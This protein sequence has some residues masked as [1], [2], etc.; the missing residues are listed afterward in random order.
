VPHTERLAQLA[1]AFGANLQPGQILFIQAETGHEALARA[2]A[3][4]AYRL[5]ARFVDVSY[6]DPHVKR[7]RIQ[8]AE[9]DTLDF[10]PPWYGERML[11]LGER[12]CARVTIA[13]STEPGILD[14]LDPGRAGRD[15][16][17]RLKEVGKVVNDRT[18][19]WTIVPFP[20]RAWAAAVYPDPDGD[21]LDRLWG[22][23]AHV[24]RLDEPD[25][26]AAWE[27]RFEETGRAAAALTDRH[28]GAIH[29]EG[30]GTDLTIGLLASSGWLNAAFST[31]DG[32]DH[33]PN[34]PSEEVFTTPDPQRADGVV[35]S[36]KPLVFP[37]GA[38]VRGLRVRFE[39]GRAAEID[40][41]ENAEILRSQCAKDEGASRLGEV[42]LVDGE[43]R[44]GPLG[45]VFYDTLLDEN[46]ASHVAVGAGFGFAIADDADRE[47]V[48]VSD[49][50]VDFMIGG[51]EVE[52]T[53][54]E[55]G[56]GRVPILRGGAWQI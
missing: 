54:I 35:T 38:S 41:D 36:T 27:R 53:G 49:I 24:L 51:D 1:V 26:V 9:R 31:V 25:P 46:A 3:E 50:H 44:I 39:G 6:F 12:R 29:F 56:G 33:R 23:V 11:A 18:T 40:A 19:N 48:N 10:V 45:T 4:H 34:L 37:G 42:A 20:T 32:I 7:A 28:F 16:L 14:D 2:I 8:H 15:L 5:G 30:P 55:R 17:P 22:E 13:G 52:V 21:A 43:G 47:R